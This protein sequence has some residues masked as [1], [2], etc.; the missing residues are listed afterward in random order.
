MNHATAGRIGAH[1]RWGKTPDRRA[2][3]EPARKAAAD[4]WLREIQVEFPNLDLA[5]QQ[6]MAD[7]R[8]REHMIRIAQL[9]RRRKAA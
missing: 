1:K 2:A 7:S 5:T 9:P 3:T 6:Q 8:R 4:K